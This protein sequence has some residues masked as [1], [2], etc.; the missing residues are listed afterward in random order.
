MK[1]RDEIAAS[2]FEHGARPRPTSR[3]IA[4]SGLLGGC[5]LVLTAYGQAHAA[6]VAVNGTCT[7]REAFD[8]VNN[9]SPAP[10][11]AFT[12]Q[13]PPAGCTYPGGSDLIIVPSGTF[14]QTDFLEI[15]RNVWVCGNGVGVTTLRGNSATS[16]FFLRAVDYNANG[17]PSMQVT[18]ERMTIDHTSGN[19][20]VTGIYAY[21]V[22]L[23]VL[24]ARVAGFGSSGI[25]GDDANV[26]I[27]DSTIENNSSF[28]S[29]GGIQFNNPSAQQATIMASL[30]I[31]RS[32]IANNTSSASGG[33]IYF[34]GGG[35]S[36]LVN[37]TISGNHA[38]DGGGISKDPLVQYIFLWFST[39]AQNTATNRGGGCSTVGDGGAQGVKLGASIVGQNTAPSGPD[40][41]GPVNQLIDSLIGNNSGTV[42]P[43]GVIDHSLINVSPN[44]DPV[45][46]DLGGPYHTKVHRPFPGSQ[47]I[48]YVLNPPSG[49]ATDDQRKVI[50]PQFG[51]W[52]P[53]MPDIGAVEIT[54]LETEALTVAAKSSDA[55][56]PVSGSQYSAGQGTNLQS[57][58]NNDFVT[59]STSGAF[60]GGTYNVKI[61]FKK[62]TSGGKFQFAHANFQNGPFTNIGGV[63]DGFASSNTW[64]TVDF[65]N[66]TFT[67]ANTK[68]FRFLVT[69]TSGTGRQIFPDFI[70]V[71]RQ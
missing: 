22:I 12:G 2:T 64:V 10:G 26:Y 50:R 70:E 44:L 29:G 68:Y 16:S 39:V 57:N 3:R 23:S 27:D 48:D 55:H 6:S 49:F 52:S 51:A 15:N 4:L 5:A 17:S 37:V 47:V 32:T 8:T 40:V 24:K 33:G 58:A 21:Q 13:A 25:I 69:G 35:T 54:R 28:F 42:I 53:S 62:G 38:V 31:T 9:Q 67:S 30:A 1:K 65:G 45:L 63:Q 20:F 60:P 61:G 46:R 56:V 7:L 18:F 66:V 59:Y 71:T 36:N 41:Y 11:C 34:S 43:P 19:A 14:T